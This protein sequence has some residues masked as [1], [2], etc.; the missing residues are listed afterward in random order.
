MTKFLQ[1]KNA[2]DG[3][4]PQLLIYG[5][6]GGWWDGIQARDF[7]EQL[8]AIDAPEIDVR[9]NSN[10]GEVFT[11]QAIYSSLKRH[12]AKINVFI[13]G[14]AASAATIV[15]MA[16]DVITMPENALMM[17]HNPLTGLWGNANEMREVADTLDKVRETMLA[18]YRNKT[19]L[20]DTKLTEL[21]DAETYMTAAEAFDLGFVD[22]V[23]EAMQVVAT[24]KKSGNFEVNGLVMAA[25]KFK[26]L[27]DHWRNAVNSQRK[28]PP[29]KTGNIENTQK[30]AK[31]MTLD[32]LKAQHPEVYAAAVEEGQT[33]ERERIKA[34]E[35]LAMVGHEALTASAK[36]E[37][38]ISPEAFA[39]EIVKAE[40]ESKGKY[41]ENR[42]EDAKVLEAVSNQ[43][44]NT[45]N[46]AKEKER[47][48][49]VSTIAGAFSAR[50]RRK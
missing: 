45:T 7:A 40:K 28:A 27:P 46:D 47:A 1:F 3:G 19:E 44:D 20:D 39:L 10:G 32:E 8:L 25:E 35:A 15:A 22:V 6:I 14:M 16:G 50:S 23:S 43:P 12:P 41:L 11:A 36:F 30:E 2:A 29:P 37:N 17:V 26:Q 13:D 4:N 38:A 49:V 34:I 33:Q 21:L 24:R 31:G 9:I 5:E 18:V 42:R 48:A